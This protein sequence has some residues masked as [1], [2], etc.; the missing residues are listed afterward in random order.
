MQSPPEPPN[1]SNKPIDVPDDVAQKPDE[2]HNE[3]RKT[4]GE[5]GNFVE[6]IELRRHRSPPDLCSRATPLS[7][8]Q[9]GRTTYSDFPEACQLPLKLILTN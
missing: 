6:G 2:E 9:K 3:Q 5:V 4:E 8:S 1:E 7:K